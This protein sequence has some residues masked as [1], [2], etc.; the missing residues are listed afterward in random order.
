LI[1]LALLAQHF[2]PHQKL[3]LH[4]WVPVFLCLNLLLL[5]RLLR[6]RV[7]LGQPSQVL[8]VVLQVLLHSMHLQLFHQHHSCHHFR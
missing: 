5:L 3:L 7:P 8:L 6:P 4:L 2:L 1:R